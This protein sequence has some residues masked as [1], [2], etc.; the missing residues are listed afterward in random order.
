MSS[1]LGLRRAISPGIAFE[2]GTDAGITCVPSSSGNGR[3]PDRRDPIAEPAR[4]LIAQ[5]SQTASS[6]HRYQ[7][8]EK[9]TTVPQ[10]MER[11]HSGAQQ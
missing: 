10:C 8:T 9:G 1:P 11:G 7:V 5:E 3:A 4:E 6:R 2:F